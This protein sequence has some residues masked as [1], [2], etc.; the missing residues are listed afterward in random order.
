MVLKFRAFARPNRA[1]AV[2]TGCMHL[3]VLSRCAFQPKRSLDRKGAK[4]Q[5]RLILVVCLIAAVTGPAGRA[6]NNTTNLITTATNAGSLYVVG[7]SGTLNYLEVRGPGGSLTAT[8]NIIGLAA[9]AGTNSATVTGSGARWIS[10]DTLYVGLT[11]SVSRL[12]VSNAAVVTHDT[13]Y[14]GHDQ[15]SRKN[16][17]LVAGANARWRAESL[18]V[19]GEAG[20]DNSLTVSNSGVVSC[21]FDSFISGADPSATN[22]TGVVT[23]TGSQWNSENGFYVGYMGAGNRLIISS[24]GVV[25]NGLGVVGSFASSNNVV[26]VTD[27]NSAW[28][29]PEGDLTIGDSQS[30]GNHL[31]VTNGGLITSL[32]AAF[33]SADVAGGNTVTVT[34]SASRWLVGDSLSVGDV[35]S[36][37]QFFIEAGGIVTNLNAVVGSE[38]SSSSNSVIVS[39]N[40]SS[41]R[42]GSL[43][44]GNDG[45]GNS[46]TVQN[47]G[48]LS[49]RTNYIGFAPAASN[50]SVL[51]NGSGS[52]LVTAQDCYV[53][54]GGTGNQLSLSGGAQ[55]NHSSTWVGTTVDSADNTLWLADSGTVLSNASALEIAFDGTSNRLVITNG[56]KAISSFGRV[57]TY[58]F[59]T[60]ALVTGTNSSWV[61]TGELYIG[62]V[63]AGTRLNIEGG[64]AISNFNGYAG[65]YNFDTA[66]TVT[67][68]GS[69]WINGGDLYVNY[70]G[71]QH[72]L[73]VS[74]GAVVS[75]LNGYVGISDASSGS[76]VQVIGAGSTWANSRNLYLGFSGLDNTLSIADGGTVRATNLVAGLSEQSSNTLV[77]V[78]A[79][80][81]IVTNPGNT[82]RIDVQRGVLALTNGTVRTSYLLLGTNATLTGTGTN[83]ATWVTNSGAIGP[84]N[85]VGRLN[86]HAALVLRPSSVL[87]F[88]LGGYHQGTTYDF[89][90]VS[91]TASLGGTL[92]VSFLNGFENTITNG[93]SFTLMSASSLTGAFA[94]VANGARLATTDGLA[95]FVVTY[96][97]ANLLLSQTRVFPRLVVT[98]PALNFGTVMAG[99]SATQT[100]QVV[101]AGG[102]ALSGSVSTLSPFAIASGGLLNLNPGQTGQVVVSFS[103]GSVGSFS[104]VVIFTSNGGNSTNPV[105]GSSMTQPPVAQF[106]ATPAT[107]FA[108][109]GVNFSDTSTGTIT[110]RFWQFGDGATINTTA[111]TVA[112]TYVLPGTNTVTLTVSGPLGVNR[113]TRS[114]YIVAAAHE[115]RIETIE[116]SANEVIVQVTTIPGR[117]YQLERCEALSSGNW[118]PVGDAA[119]G[120]GGLVALRD[121]A[122]A[123]LAGAFYRVREFRVF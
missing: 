4:P 48:M 61:N 14:I 71:L 42:N 31:L 6:E 111:T 120:T 87:R 50:N 102:L 65:V 116:I 93:A 58:G 47:G 28:K 73:I 9:T 33:G 30:T 114:N 82:A 35:G 36:L 75:S 20:S 24:G 95:D 34:G 112:H 17:A 62:Q 97:G 60:R 68:P 123:G 15:N 109:F 21:G 16:S 12:V 113:L 103:P 122:G 56:A 121:V 37:N 51:I 104:N 59:L 64:G 2:V 8:N 84:G 53:G 90:S 117:S 108:P 91:N 29:M 3:E 39:G 107:G 52:R 88:E 89:L 86:L 7:K 78:S 106:S 25:S 32:T 22:N 11:G 92:A 63:G 115:I 76:M 27:A 41:W 18:L 70:G 10:L 81:L 66:V 40:G 69:R 55:A 13:A 119:A 110:N 105:T 98:P 101:N 80:S 1:K 44:V 5:R 96:A 19:V 118:T 49:A 77:S 67:G 43:T 99:S 26:T 54:Y 79:G 38:S 94:N 100:L 46:V 72:Q 23:G 57:S 83:I 85:F 74:N 45:A